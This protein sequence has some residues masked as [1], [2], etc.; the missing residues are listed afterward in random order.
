M[1]T[2]WKQVRGDGSWW[3]EDVG[4]MAPVAWVSSERGER[5]EAVSQ[6]LAR[7]PGKEEEKR[8]ERRKEKKRKKKKKK[9]G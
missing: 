2:G 9:S 4:G 1:V 7:G 5:S 6:W 8:N 3:R